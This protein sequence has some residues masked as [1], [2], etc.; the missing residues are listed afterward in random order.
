MQN[1]MKWQ[2]TDTEVF[3]V[4]ANGERTVILLMHYPDGIDG[5]D[6]KGW[7]YFTFREVADSNGECLAFPGDRQFHESMGAAASEALRYYANLP[8]APDPVAMAVYRVA[9]AICNGSARVAD[10]GPETIIT[11][12]DGEPF[13]FTC[14]PNGRISIEAD[15]E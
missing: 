3:A 13:A 10:T 7:L 14:E 11:G 1:R 6:G 4:Y 9:T 12:N 15:P 2:G 5:L 8:A